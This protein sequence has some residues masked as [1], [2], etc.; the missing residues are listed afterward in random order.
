LI[1]GGGTGGHIIP[2]V[3][4]G[5]ALVARGHPAS[6]IWFVGSDRELDRRLIPAAGFRLVTLPGRGIVRRWTWSNVKAVAGLLRA[7]GQALALVRRT[8][9]RVVVAVGGYASFACALAAVLCRVPLVVAEQ[10]AAPGLVNRLVGRFGAV[11]AVSFEGTPLP[12]AVVTGN[13]VRPEIIAIDRAKPARRAAREQLGL[14]L[15]GMVVAAAG[16]S[17]GA[18]RI[19]E[20][21]IQLAGLWHDRPGIAIHHVV[22]ERDRADFSRRGSGLSGGELVYQQVAFEDRMD[23]LL[24][25]ADVAVQRAGASTVSELTVAGLPSVLA[26]LPGAPG[27][28]QMLNARRL[29]DAGAAVLVPDAELDGVRLASELDRL[30]GDED[31]L[32]RMGAAARALGH[33]HAADDVAALAEKY[34]R[35]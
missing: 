31:L 11:S 26:P 23:L 4:I 14:P 7:T 29:A 34:A 18:R 22:G 35:A 28:H 33:P 27:D 19:N 2:A 1:A 21:V 17:L 13:P 25:A 24:A 32:S 8:R 20:A 9:P 3:A 5:R 30:L 12:R 16:G 6:S 15:D 10:N